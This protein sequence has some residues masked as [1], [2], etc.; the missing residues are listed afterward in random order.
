MATYLGELI[1]RRIAG[2]PIEHPLFD[3]HFDAIPMYSGKPWF[4]PVVGAYYQV[5]DWLQ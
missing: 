2:E 3:D 1:G 4:L 5:K